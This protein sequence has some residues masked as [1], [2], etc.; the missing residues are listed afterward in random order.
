MSG[1]TPGPWFVAGSEPENLFGSSIG[2]EIVDANGF[3]IAE[4]PRLVLKNGWENDP[5]TT[6]HWGTDPWSH[7]DR[8]PDEIAANA[9]LI[10]AA[11]EMLA[12]LIDAKRQLEIYEQE[13]TGE[14]FNDLEINAA[15]AKA[16]GAAS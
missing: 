10:A 12:A 5:R 15:I 16:T 6:G 4:A 7:F 9:R 13:A 8:T 14:T 3:S 2:S 11:P 1:H